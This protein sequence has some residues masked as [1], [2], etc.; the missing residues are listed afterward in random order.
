[1]MVGVRD[2]QPVDPRPPGL[3]H[4]E[5]RHVPAWIRYQGAWRKASVHAWFQHGDQWIAWV[6]HQTTDPDDPH[7][8]WGLFVFDGET[9]R[10]RHYP[11][12]RA[13][14]EVSSRWGPSQT[15]KTRLRDLGYR[16]D[17]VKT[18]DEHDVLKLG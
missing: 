9:I 6:Q 12:A 7:A 14:V 13:S 15:V 5:P 10:R 2:A 8:L 16:V 1:M 17:H 11:A 4:V 3:R 18:G